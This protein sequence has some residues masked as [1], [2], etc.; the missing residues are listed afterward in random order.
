MLARHEQLGTD[1]LGFAL[2]GRAGFRLLPGEDRRNARLQDARLL[3]GDLVQRRTQEFR[4]VDRDRHDEAGERT[5]DH[6]GG[7]EPAAEADF[8]EQ[9]VGWMARKEQK[10]R[11]GRDL[12]KRD[13][14]LGVGPLAFHER[15]GERLVADQPAGAPVRE[16]KPLVE[17]HEI[18]RGIDVNAV[19]G[20]LQHRAQEGD[21]RALAVG[22]GD[23]DHRRQLALGM[24]EA[25]Q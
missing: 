10:R 3:G 21:G 6:V 25:G 8:Q 20:R 16:A 14:I 9:H 7:I 22:A 23:V 17:A 12:E 11:R 13:R 24:T 1:A 19:A 5:L 15:V 18:G 4:M 2:D